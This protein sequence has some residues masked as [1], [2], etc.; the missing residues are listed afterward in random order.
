MS[1]QSV[2]AVI[3]NPNAGR[4]HGR[5]IA[6]EAVSKLKSRGIETEVFTSS[7]PG[8]TLSLAQALDQ[9]RYVGI[10]VVGGDGSMFEVLNGLYAG[11]QGLSIPVGQIPTGTGNSFIRDLGIFGVDDAVRA[12]S[13]DSRCPVDLGHCTLEGRTCQFINIMGAGFVANVARRAGKYKLFG[14][15]SYLFGTLEELVHLNPVP[16]QL[17]VDGETIEHNAIFVEFCNSRLTGGNM[18]MAP[19]A[20]IDDGLF[21]IVV[22]TKTTRRRALKLLPTIFTG[23]HLNEPEIKVYRGGSIKLESAHPM[24]L[25]IDGE[26]FGHTP[27]EIRI[28]ARALQVYGFAGEASSQSTAR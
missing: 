17:H 23:E 12:I 28:A 16:I 18:L 24:A 10:V 21:D 14:A 27:I 20:K 9:R 6:E 1:T 3:V 22:L 7:R 4:K 5:R 11:G 25:N 8:E 15:K 2:H 26:I 19:M 13:A